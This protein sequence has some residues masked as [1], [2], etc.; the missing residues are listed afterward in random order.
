MVESR[1]RASFALEAFVELLTRCLDS[2][3]AAKPRVA[4]AVNLAHAAFAEKRDDFVGAEFFTGFQFHEGR[5]F[6]QI[7]AKRVAPVSGRSPSGR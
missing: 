4:S 7:Y 5:G 3:V 6:H 2:D 1:D